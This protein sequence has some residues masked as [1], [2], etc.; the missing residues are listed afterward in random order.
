MKITLTYII[1][2]ILLISLFS[3]IVSADIG[4]KPT[5]NIDVFYNDQPI[6]DD[7]FYAK[8]LDCNSQSRNQVSGE[9]Q[10][11]CSE[12]RSGECKKSKCNFEPASSID[13]KIPNGLFKL[14]V[15]IP[16]MNKAFTSNIIS[17]NN[18][19]SNYRMDINSDGSAKIVENTSFFNRTEGINLLNFTIALIL[20]LILELMVAAIFLRRLKIPNKRI[21][22][23]ILVLNFI[24]LPIVWFIYPQT[25]LPIK[26]WELILLLAEIFIVVFEGYFIYYFN[27]EL[28]TLKKSFFLSILM[29]IV[30]TLIGGF[31][32]ILI[33]AM[34]MLF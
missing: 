25:N 26:S 32:Y 24:S 3:N 30:S 11:I 5:L 22:T 8:I 10:T 1:S 34:L 29:N 12:F 6:P 31:I 2:T 17:T 4:P 7:V 16:S 23:S 27:R 14:E 19:N 20:T 9:W 33:T 18:F 15:N 28:I 21:L 13:Y